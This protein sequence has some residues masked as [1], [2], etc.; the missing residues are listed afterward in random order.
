MMRLL[1]LLLEHQM[2]M[3]L[4]LLLRYGWREHPCTHVGRLRRLLL[5]LLV[6]DRIAI[7]VGVHVDGDFRMS[8][9]INAVIC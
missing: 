6:L 3:E 8:I 9:C 2:L 5:L 7:G 1:L 4:H